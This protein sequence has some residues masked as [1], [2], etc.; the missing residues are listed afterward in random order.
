MKKFVIL[1]LTILLATTI[2]FSQNISK[3]IEKDSIVSITSRQLKETNLI[4]IEHQKLLK[5][6]TLL[7][8]QLDNYQVEN[9]LLIQTDS[10]KTLQLQ[11]YEQLSKAYT[12]KIDNLSKEISRKNRIITTWKV[13]GITVSVGLAIW[14]LL[15]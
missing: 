8:D 3:E 1:L 7:L 2:S 13:G 5:Q 6:H 12:V 11:N 4:F 9:S 14:L 10:L 15:K